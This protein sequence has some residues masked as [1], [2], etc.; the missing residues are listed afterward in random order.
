MRKLFSLLLVIIT[1][2]LS[3]S[4]CTKGTASG[5]EYWPTEEW[6]F[7][8][9]ENQQMN[10]D[11]LNGI[12]T[13]ISN[14]GYAVD[15]VVVVR[16]G[17]IVYE[18]YRGTKY[19]KDTV[20][21]IYSCTKSVLGTLVGIAI[22]DGDIPGLNTKVMDYYSDRTIQNM[23]ERKAAITIENLLEMC[24]GLQW[25][26][27]S[28][29]YTN[30][31]NIWIQALNS[32]DTIQFVLDQPM[33]TDPGTKWNYCGGYSY[34]LADI[35]EKATGKDILT[36]ATEKIFTPLGITNVRWSKDRSGK[37]E[38]AGGLNLTARDMAKFGE[39]ILYNGQWEGKQIV[40]EAYVAA[41]TTSRHTT[42][43]TTG[44]GYESWW[45]AIKEGFFYCN[46]IYGQ[47]IYVIPQKNI[48]V[49][50]ACTI[51][52]PDRETQLRGLVNTYVVGAC[53]DTE[54]TAK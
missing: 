36:Y 18:D 12:E 47:R 44:Y 5:P 45:I 48:V 8:K 7:A 53:T 30:P 33:A 13:G 54:T 50:F 14:L 16:N 42:S 11:I 17:F 28:L 40:P 15:S 38:A 32:G 23:D 3:V 24:G 41:A 39:L 2:V 52:D 19:L 4:G 29:P 35:L 9:P 10:P 46:G 1:I 34:I 20:H 22:A 43:A 26:E 31:N 25:S 6:L 21:P 51:P 37:Y 27:W 49:V